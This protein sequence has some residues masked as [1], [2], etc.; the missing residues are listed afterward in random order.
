MAEKD[1]VYKGKVKQS[2]IFDFKAF[3]D[4]LY[5]NLMDSHYDVFEKKYGEIKKGEA[6]NLDIE[7]GA[8]KPM[9]RGVSKYFLGV[10]TVRYTVLGLQKV[11]VKRGDEEVSMDSAT[12]ELDFMADLIKD[13][14]NKWNS[15]F[16][17]FL[18]NLYEKYIIKSRIEDYEME[19]YQDIMEV[20]NAVKAYL[21]I[22]G[23]WDY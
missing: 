13:P 12:L 15:P 16:Y 11:K 7:W 1:K 21:A 20:I 19:I 18:R 2:G 4:F 3:Y 8:T 17:K 9:G 10:I 5:D 14:E 22:E 23:R 6:K